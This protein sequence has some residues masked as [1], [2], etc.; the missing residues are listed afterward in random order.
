MKF[1]LKAV[2]LFLIISIFFLPAVA[3]DNMLQYDMEDIVSYPEISPALL[4]F[5][6]HPEK[7]T[8]RGLLYGGGISRAVPSR[9]N[10]YH[11]GNAVMPDLT[12]VFVLYNMT[13]KNAEVVLR[14]TMTGPLKDPFKVGHGLAWKYLVFRQRGE[15]RGLILRPGE[16]R[17]VFSRR[18]PPEEV[19]SGIADMT[20]LSG[21]PL[22]FA[23]FALSHPGETFSFPPPEAE[24]DVHSWGAYPLSEIKMKREFTPFDPD[25]AV[26]IGDAVIDT[27]VEGRHLRGSYGIIHRIDFTLKNPGDK[28]GEVSIFFQPRGGPA[29]FT[30][31]LNG[32]LNSIPPTKAYHQVFLAKVLLPPGGE[33]AIRIITM[34]E[35]ASNY[36]VRILLRGRE[37][38][39]AK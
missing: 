20:V 26:T 9:F 31:T 8:E 15:C 1:F 13:S 6:D 4:H 27:V 17:I 22:N 21:G 11:Q 38:N 12:L 34:P 16:K 36:P 2:F 7:V 10:F 18:L 28:P 23:L 30:Y 35:G 29:A 39:E 19:I 3:A 25:M 37:V 5:S 14:D 32:E 24:K 33:K